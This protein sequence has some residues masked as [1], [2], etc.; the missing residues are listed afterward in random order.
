MSLE[1]IYFDEMQKGITRGAFVL[2]PSQWTKD[3]EKE[4]IESEFLDHL[5]HFKKYILPN[6]PNQ[7]MV[8]DTYDLCPESDDD[9]D[10]EDIIKIN[11]FKE[12]AIKGLS[13][14]LGWSPTA[15][16]LDKKKKDNE[17]T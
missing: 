10:D 8:F 6:G 13:I 9:D 2:D 3:E 17:T 16:H 5:K 15:K 1:S 4:F 14:P 12:L 11:R 7:I